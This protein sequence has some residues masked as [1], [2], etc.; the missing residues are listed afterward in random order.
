[1]ISTILVATDGSATSSAALDVAIDEAGVHRADL[2]VLCVVDSSIPQ[3]TMAGPQ[4]DVLDV[5]YQIIT[6]ALTT[7]AEQVLEAASAAAET[8]GIRAH[9]HLEYGDPRRVIIATAE[10]M[11]AD[12]IVIGSTGRTGLEALLLGSVSSS[13]VTHAKISTLVVRQRT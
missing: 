12:L 7:E 8:A 9:L 3:S 10:E 13:V 1:M 11:G 2:H 6:D 5:N 4:S